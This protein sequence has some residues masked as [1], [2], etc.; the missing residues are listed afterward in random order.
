M[1]RA[2]L[3]ET[4]AFS[5]CPEAIVSEKIRKATRKSPESRTEVYPKPKRLL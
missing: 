2:H 1:T 3:Y 5:L 4:S